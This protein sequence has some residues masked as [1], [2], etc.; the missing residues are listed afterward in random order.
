MVREKSVLDSEQVA[1]FAEQGYVLLE[2][3]LTN[4]QLIALRTRFEDWVNESRQFS[5]S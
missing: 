3:A 1:S 2:Y 4:V 5:G